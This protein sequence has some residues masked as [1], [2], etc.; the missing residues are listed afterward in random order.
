MLISH[1]DIVDGVWSS[2][3]ISARVYVSFDLEK[4]TVIQPKIPLN[5]MSDIYFVLITTVSSN[6]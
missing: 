3:E 6:Y 2:S 5:F 1:I 4:E